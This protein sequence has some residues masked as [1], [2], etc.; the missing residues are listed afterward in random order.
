MGFSI[1]IEP[2]DWG[3]MCKAALKTEVLGGGANEMTLVRLLDEMEG[4]QRRWHADEGMY[5]EERIR[6]FGAKDDCRQ[7][8]EAAL[9]LRS[10]ES[11]RGMVRGMD[12]G[13]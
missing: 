1:S 10:I 2:R 13:D 5:T 9:C 7:K 6:M 3:K 8:P 12:W 11:V 4:R